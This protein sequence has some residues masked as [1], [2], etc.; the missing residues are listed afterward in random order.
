MVRELVLAQDRVIKLL[1]GK[2]VRKII[3]VP[4]RIVN[5]VV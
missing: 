3:V 4:N 2:P 1:E 5:V